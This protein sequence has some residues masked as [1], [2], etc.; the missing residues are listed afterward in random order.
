MN[1]DLNAPIIPGRSAAGVRLEESVNC[2]LETNTPAQVE[3][4]GEVT[5][6]RFGG[7]SLFVRN[8][9]I[10]QIG[11]HQGFSG[12]M[13]GV[14]IGTTIAEV[15][16]LLGPVIEDEDDNLAVEG[17]EG[18]CFESTEFRPPFSEVAKNLDAT[19]KEMFVYVPRETS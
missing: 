8:G 18:W 13:R 16:R 5:V 19:V 9:A 10:D 14:T 7:V 3:D 6:Y 1:F 4:R 12:A 15:S 17:I 2:V 11:V